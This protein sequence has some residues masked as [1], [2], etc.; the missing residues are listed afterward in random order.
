MNRVVRVGG[1]V[2]FGDEGIAPWLRNTEYGRMLIRNNPLYACEIPLSLLPD[3]ARSAK[4]SWEVGNCFYVIEFNVA[5]QPPPANIDVQH[6]GARG[7][8]IRTRYFGQL[9]GVDPALRDRVY[10]EAE[11]LGKSRVE[12]IESLLRNSLPM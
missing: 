9:E 5:E 6:L 2:V 7:G 10:S 1:K 3:S 11:R 12:Y 8:S 4:L